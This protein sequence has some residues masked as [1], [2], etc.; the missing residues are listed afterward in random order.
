M[1]LKRTAIL[2]RRPDA[3]YLSVPVRKEP[4]PSPGPRTKRC[5]SCREEF[6]PRNS[7]ARA[8]SPG[9]AVVLAIAIRQKVERKAAKADRADTK[10][11]L[12]ELAPLTVHAA[13]AQAA[14]NRYVRL[15]D[16][17]LPCCSC[18]RPATWDG[19][20]HASHF[21][22]RGSNSALRFHMWNLHKACSICNNHLSGNI[23]EYGIR[24]A[25]RFGQ[26]RVDFL[27]NHP[28]SREYSMEYLQRITKIF[29]KKANRL[30]RA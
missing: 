2:R 10:R 26:E 29:T 21:K 19:Q 17:H 7:M 24:L 18:D 15:R 8:C 5:A 9:C 28:R 20:W 3:D 23:G 25:E 1:P 16:A 4:K 14:V 6:V 11:R 13:R 22:S 30:N 12:N 27:H